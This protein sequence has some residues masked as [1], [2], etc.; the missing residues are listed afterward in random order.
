[1]TDGKR[2]EDRENRT[3]SDRLIH[4][5]LRGTDKARSLLQ[6]V[7]EAIGV[8][9]VVPASAAPA[10]AK[11]AAVDTAST[12]SAVPNAAGSSDSVASSS[13]PAELGVSDEFVT[14]SM[15]HVLLRQ[16]RVRDARRVFERVLALRPGDA[17]AT[18][19]LAECGRANA[20]VPD[21]AG[22][23]AVVLPRADDEPREM[24]DRQRPPRAYGVSEIHVLPVDPATIAIVWEVTD[25]D[26]AHAR[27]LIDAQCHLA[28]CVL[29]RF[30]SVDGERREPRW[31]EWVPAVGDFF[32][33]GLATGAQHDVA[34]GMRGSDGSFVAVAKADA[35]RA[36][37]G[38]PA[39]HAA[40]VQATV[41][42]PPVDETRAAVVSRIV[43]VHTPDGASFDVPLGATDPLSAWAALR[44]EPSGVG[45]DGRAPRSPSA[46]GRFVVQHATGE[47]RAGGPGDDDVESLTW[48]DQDTLRVAWS[49]SGQWR[50]A[51]VRLDSGPGLAYG[52]APVG[53]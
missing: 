15:G 24:L 40:D 11:R 23:V 36:P 45:D 1:M 49:S 39:V 3:L 6:R 28:I 53:A 50:W 19:G 14:S 52:S 20:V 26:V 10:P 30:D 44:G 4:G 42:V 38:R 31:I 27:A 5:L 21:A 48:R 25:T 33:R 37:R 12:T 9:D 8:P 41:R 7:R 32:V 16:G 2:A 46:F 17:D 29:S 34:I 18:A 22:D 51:D 35:V 13:E 47:L 43:A